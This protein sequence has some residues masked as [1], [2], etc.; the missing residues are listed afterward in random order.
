MELPRLRVQA[1]LEFNSVALQKKAMFLIFRNEPVFV[2]KPPGRAEK[3]LVLVPVFVVHKASFF[4]I[5]VPAV[6]LC[7]TVPVVSAPESIDITNLFQ[8]ES[9]GT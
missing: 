6:V 3:P 5:K 2:R 4:F 8:S 9:V 7:F 1:L